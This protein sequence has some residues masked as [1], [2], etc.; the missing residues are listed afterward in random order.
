MEVQ[1]HW[2]QEVRVNSF[3]IPATVEVTGDFFFG[4]K[5]TV[6][7]STATPGRSEVLKCRE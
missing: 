3:T 1:Q 4:N 7:I 2:I 6:E 5:T